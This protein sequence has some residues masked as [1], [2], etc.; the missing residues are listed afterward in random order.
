MASSKETHYMDEL[1]AAVRMKP[2]MPVILMLFAVIGFLLFFFVWAGI[3]EI[4][5]LTRGQGQVVPSQEIQVVQSL[6]GGI[7][8]ELL[9]KKGEHVKK[10]QVILRISDVLFSS[11]ERGTQARFTALEAKKARLT[12]EARGEEFSMP[13]GIQSEMPAM[14]DNERALY[15]SRQKELNAAYS[16]QDENIKK[17]SADLAEVKA[18]INRLSENKRLLGQELA[19][20]RDMVSKR[21]VPKLEQIRLEREL[22]DINGQMNVRAQEKKGLKASLASAENERAAQGDKFKS[23]A[24]EELNKVE[25]EIAS[26]KENLKSIGDRVDRTEIRAPVD[27]IV[28]QI[29]LQTIGGVVEPAMKLVEIVPMNDALKIIAKV[30]PN[31]I[32]F[33]TEGMPVK[34]KVSAYDSQRYGSLDGILSRVAANSVQDKDDNVM[35]EVEV[36]TTKNYL[37]TKEKPLPITSG[38][39]ADIEVITGKRTILHYLMKPLRRGF[40]RALRER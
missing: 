11:E 40:E 12:A 22:A 39:V 2:A 20:T 31:E 15:E 37:G 38:M 36:H 19:I 4:E 30:K 26:L 14:A 10:G 29:N 17:A 6:E 34:V 16:I 35:F 9:I 23:V 25:S 3:T 1:E 28:N 7:L 13:H 21:A 27:G 24:L 33:I 18:E 32:A 8:Q 5:E